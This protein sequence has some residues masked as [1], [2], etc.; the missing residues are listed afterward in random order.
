[1]T[2]KSLC[3]GM[4]LLAAATSTTHAEIQY[5]EESIKAGKQL[6]AMNC[7]SCH[8]NDGKATVNFVADATNLTAP[9]QW[10]GGNT[11]QHIFDAIKGGQAV[12]MPAY[13]WILS[14]DEDIWHLTNFVLSLWPEEARQKALAE[15][16][17]Q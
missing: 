3:L 13:E 5:N 2:F 14:G 12:D 17:S 6:F 1:M 15:H 10:R 11:R 9:A 8:G 16:E 4:S 7:T